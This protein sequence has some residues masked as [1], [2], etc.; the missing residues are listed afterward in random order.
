MGQAPLELGYEVRRANLY[1]DGASLGN[2]GS[3]GIG[4][5]LT[6]AEGNLLAELSE[7][8]GTATNNEAEYRALV[9]GLELAHQHQI[10]HLNWYSDSELLVK[11]WLGRYKVHQPHLLR[12]LKQV[13]ERG[14][15]FAEF[16]AH[17]IPR[18]QNRRADRLAKQGAKQNALTQASGSS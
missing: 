1:T 9:R 17:H 10:T 3:A 2:P 7:P 12:L 16:R 4:V 8:I 6:D 14:K 13:R 11:Q 15:K 18:E 5:V